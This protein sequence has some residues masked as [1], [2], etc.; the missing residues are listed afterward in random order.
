MILTCL[1]CLYITAQAENRRCHWRADFGPQCYQASFQW[2]GS[3]ASSGCFWSGKLHIVFI[4]Q[5][6]GFCCIFMLFFFFIKAHSQCVYGS[7]LWCVE[8]SEKVPPDASG[9]KRVHAAWWCHVKKP[10]N[11]LIQYGYYISLVCLLLHIIKYTL[12]TVYL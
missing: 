6:N 5:R 10:V 3:W 2:T 11:A 8:G 7:G 1:S 9:C 12:Y 4:E